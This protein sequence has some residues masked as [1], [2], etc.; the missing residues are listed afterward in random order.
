MNRQKIWTLYKEKCKNTKKN[1]WK[2][3]QYQQSRGKWESKIYLGDFPG[4]P[5]VKC[6]SCDAGDLGLILGQ[7]TKVP[8]ASENLSPRPQLLKAVR[9]V[10]HTQLESVYRSTKF[11]RPQWRPNAVNKTKLYWDNRTYI[12]SLWMNENTI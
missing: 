4:G 3:V 8:Q 9:S 2:T 12:Q 10:A 7:G 5:V 6:L 1:T 11:H